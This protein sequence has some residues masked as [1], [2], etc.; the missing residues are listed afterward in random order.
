MSL[1]DLELQHSSGVYRKRDRVLVR[2]QGAHVWDERG[3]RYIDCAAGIAVASVG[4]THPRLV[5]AIARQ[6]QTLMTCHE[7]FPNDQRARFL[8]RLAAV[9]PASINR[10]FLCNSGTEA[11]EAAIKFA[12]LSTRRPG[13][14]AC[15]RAFHGR[16]LGALSATHNPK[17]REPFQPLVPGFTHVRFNDV[18]QLR[19]AVCSD[20]AAV[21]VEIVQGEGGVHVATPEFLH[22]AREACD[23]RN[24]LVIV[25]EVQTGFGRTGRWFACEHARLEPDLLCLGKA[26]AGGVPMGAVGIGPRVGALTPGCHGSTFGGSPLACAAGRA[27]L[28]IIAEERLV[29]RS[30]RLGDHLRRRLES[31]PSRLIRGVRSMGLM[32]GVELRMRA[33]AVVTALLDRGVLALTAGSTVL[34]LVPPLVIEESDLD[35][36]VDALASVLEEKQRA[37]EVVSVPSPQ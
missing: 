15:A 23:E 2:G 22:A 25:D 29:E 7:T 8:E 1:V 5:E 28:E 6:A 9:T 31:I 37:T 10:F 35:Q 21:I 20:T 36:V 12:R 34:R 26:I 24:A 18:S 14:V 17:Y 13:I 19:S 33:A 11:V 3:R 4:H 27:T 32:V 30:A 16:T